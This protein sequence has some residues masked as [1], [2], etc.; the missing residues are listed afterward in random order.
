MPW[1]GTY[2]AKGGHGLCPLEL[3][4]S[5]LGLGPPAAQVAN[6]SYGTWSPRTRT[7]YFV[8]E[9]EQGRLGAW[10][11]REGQWQRRGSCE[12]GGALP[13]YVALDPAKSYLA[14]ANY[15]TGSLALI[16]VDGDSG[17]IRG[18]ADLAQHSGRGPNQER[19][20]G[21]H[22][23]CTM[24]DED[25]A[26]IYTVDLGLDR[27]LRYPLA[28]GRL[29]EGE[30]AFEAPPGSGPRHLLLHPDLRAAAHLARRSS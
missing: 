12:T 26:A 21:P 25:G 4:E 1:V 10:S 8:D 16:A 6:A 14:V 15:G 7:A 18:L 30:I 3:A 28:D 20:E 19:Q 29:G 5:G 13:C 22:V 17:E 9:Q 24:F 27:V 11:L 23:H 2:Q